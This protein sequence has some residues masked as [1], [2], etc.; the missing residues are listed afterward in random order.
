MG[1]LNK[2]AL[3]RRAL[4]VEASAQSLYNAANLE[5]HQLELHQLALIRSQHVFRQSKVIPRGITTAAR[6]TEAY[7]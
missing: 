2:P 7:S 1:F 4:V 5:L 3:V 6:K